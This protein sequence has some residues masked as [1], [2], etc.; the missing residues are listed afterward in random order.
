MRSLLTAL[1]FF[2]ACSNAVAQWQS[3]EAVDPFTDDRIRTFVLS[4]ELLDGAQNDV[5]SR[6]IYRINDDLTRDFYWVFPEHHFCVDTDPKIMIR[7]GTEAPEPLKFTLS[8]D[9]SAAFFSSPAYVASNFGRLKKMMLR[10]EDK[11]GN[12]STVSYEGAL[13]VE[14]AN[15][16]LDLSDRRRWMMAAPGTLSKKTDQIGISITDTGEVGK[17]FGLKSG[18]VNVFI[19]R[20]LFDG[21]LDDVDVMVTLGNET[22]TETIIE[23]PSL[24][25]VPGFYGYARVFWERE[26][27]D[28]LLDSVRNPTLTVK[29]R[30]ETYEMD[31]SQYADVSMF[32]T[33]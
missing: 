6:L 13:P 16:Y 27:G 32:L 1:L 5:N 24:A 3:L 15:Y 23:D 7:F 33:E 2:C 11:C 17:Q 20:A 8:K 22:F 31:I 21:S 18:A 30:E 12:K 25:D 26:L 4:G 10:L 29:V 9:R 28:F 14:L 19:N